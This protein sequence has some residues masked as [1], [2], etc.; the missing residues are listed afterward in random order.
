M[1]EKR[2]TIALA[3]KTA[4]FLALRKEERLSGLQRA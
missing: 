3:K 2:H 4:C 1:V